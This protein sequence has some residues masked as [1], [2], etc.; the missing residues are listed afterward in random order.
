MSENSSTN[1]PE[2]FREVEPWTA[3][4][5]VFVATVHAYAVSFDMP[6]GSFGSCVPDQS[7]ALSIPEA[8]A[9]RDWL[10]RALPEEKP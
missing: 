2:R 1:T 9:L 6:G 7:R 5:S 3:T 8:R 10:T 4:R